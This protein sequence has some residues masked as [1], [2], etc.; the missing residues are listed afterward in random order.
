MSFFFGGYWWCV[1]GVWLV[2]VHG[3]GV[4]GFEVDDGYFAGVGDEVEHFLVGGLCLPAGGV[5]E[6][7]AAVLVDGG[8]VDVA[9][10]EDVGCFV[11]DHVVG[12]FWCEG[13]VA[14][15]GGCEVAFFEHDFHDFGGFVVFEVGDVGGEVEEALAV[16]GEYFDVVEAE[17]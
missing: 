3:G 1:L 13:G 15:V 5:D 4:A 7:D 10:D 14:A 17:V 16:V 8:E 2:E 6:G 9:G 11:D 12:V